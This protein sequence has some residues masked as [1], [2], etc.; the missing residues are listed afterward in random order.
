MVDQ[1]KILLRVG[2]HKH[3]YNHCSP[4]CYVPGLTNSG[5][6]INSIL[7][8][9]IQKTKARYGTWRYKCIDVRGGKFCVDEASVKTESCYITSHGSRLKAF[10]TDWLLALHISHPFFSSVTHIGAGCCRAHS[11]YCTAPPSTS[12]TGGW[13]GRSVAGSHSSTSAASTTRRGDWGPYR[14]I[15]FNPRQ[16][17]PKCILP[18]ARC[19]RCP[20]HNST[21][22]AHATWREVWQKSQR[23]QTGPNSPNWVALKYLT[24]ENFIETGPHGSAFLGPWKE[25]SEWQVPFV[26]WN[27]IYSYMHMCVHVYT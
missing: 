23:G 7:Q 11:Y 1:K 21:H 15:P 10:S 5:I 26:S 6:L 25:P 27:A 24:F 18:S 3:R 22:E 19:P 16:M 14:Y 9:S 4:Y 8:V 20:N 2:M 12:V 17:Y 13:A